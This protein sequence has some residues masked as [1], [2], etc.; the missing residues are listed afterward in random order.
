MKH[1]SRSIL[2]AFLLAGGAITYLMLHLLFQSGRALPRLPWTTAPL[3]AFIAASLLLTAFNVNRRL[4]ERQKSQEK[5]TQVEQKEMNPLFL[6]RLLLL[7]KSSSHGGALL[8]GIYLGVVVTFGTDLPHSNLIWRP[9]LDAT[10]AILVLIGGYVLERVLSI[11]D[12]GTE[13]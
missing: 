1:T 10:S 13:A 8:G 11:K 5:K 4:E 9:V 2:A 3:L 12:D 7:A 6:A